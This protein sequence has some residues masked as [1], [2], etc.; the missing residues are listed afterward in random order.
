MPSR[1][2]FIDEKDSCAP[3]NISR[4]LVTLELPSLMLVYLTELATTT[5]MKKWV[6]EINLKDSLEHYLESGI[7]KSYSEVLL[8]KYTQNPFSKGCHTN[9]GVGIFEDALVVLTRF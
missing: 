3:A 5:L 4:Y 9:S 6:T 1:R 8:Q 7:V 2:Y